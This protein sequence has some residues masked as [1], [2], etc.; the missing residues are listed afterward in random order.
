MPIRPEIGKFAPE[1]ETKVAAAAPHVTLSP[2]EERMRLFD[3]AAR[4]LQ[5]LAAGTGLLV[6][7]D[8][9]HWADQGTL[10]LLH[11]LLRHLRND[12]VLFLAAYREVELDRTHPLASALVDWN[13]ERLAVRVQL[14]RLSRADTAALIAALFGVDRVSDEL[15]VALYRETEGNPFFVEEVIK[16]LIEQGEIYREGDSWGRKETQ[17]LSIPQSVKEAIGRRLTRLGE[18]TVD[19]LRTAAALGKHFRFGELAAVSAASD[20]ALLDALDEASAAQLVRATSEGA[21][22]ASGT[23]DVFAFTHDKI[24]EVLYEELN[25]IRRR[26]LHQRIGEAVEALHGSGVGRCNGNRRARAGSRPSFHARRG[27]CEVAGLLA[28][29]S[30]QRGAGVRA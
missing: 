9:I 12:R 13:R 20:D 25:P 10:S 4:F 22:G 27:P 24:R 7:I 28:P 21:R 16:S 11:Y 2:S 18:S 26:R 15:V 23:D 29:R 14:G 17:E 19:A 3:H 6:F 5:S 8:D 1:I 30:A